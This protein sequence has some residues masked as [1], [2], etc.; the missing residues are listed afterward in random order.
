M[1]VIVT[2]RNFHNINREE[3]MPEVFV[4]NKN[5][6]SEEA[7]RR[8]WEYAY[9]RA[10]TES[11]ESGDQLDETGCWFGED[12]AQIAW[13]DGDKKEFYLIEVEEY[14]KQVKTMDETKKEELQDTLTNLGFM[15]THAEPAKVFA[16]THVRTF[17]H[18]YDQ[19]RLN[20]NLEWL[21]DNGYISYKAIKKGL[22]QLAVYKKRLEE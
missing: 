7:F 11:K 6:T 8:I 12:M 14:G 3:I 4:P 20:G 2:Y 18:C 9:N 13:E 21:R 1:K 5:E 19:E 15:A 22:T 17:L 16:W 10:L